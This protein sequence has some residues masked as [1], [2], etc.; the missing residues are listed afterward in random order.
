MEHGLTVGV[1]AMKMLI[2]GFATLPGYMIAL[3][4]FC[5]ATEA[6][7]ELRVTVFAED[8][9]AKAPFK[10]LDRPNDLYHAFHGA[11]MAMMLLPFSSIAID[12]SIAW[13]YVALA[14]YYLIRLTVI[15]EKVPGFVWW[16]DL[17]HIASNLGLAYMFRMD[18]QR[19]MTTGM[20]VSFFLWQGN[21][22]ILLVWRHV[23]ARKRDRYYVGGSIA[24]IG[25]AY[26]MTLML[27]WPSRFMCM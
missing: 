2:V 1:N 22:Y 12:A 27:V 3:A 14:A 18:I 17:C 20:F 13:L 5:T 4:A 16:Y 21:Y 19:D 24:H 7:Y 23:A 15:R 9:R 8:A 25:L 6:F 26:I 10:H 11:G